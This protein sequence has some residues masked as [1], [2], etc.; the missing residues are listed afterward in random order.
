METLHSKK[1]SDGGKRGPSTLRFVDVQEIQDGIVIL[2]DGSL[3]AILAVSSLNFDLK[4]FEEQEAIIGQYQNFLNSLDFPVQIIVLSRR[5]NI[6]PYLKLLLR[7]EASQTNEL[8]RMQ[9]GEYARFIKSLTE[10]A[11]IMTKQFYII[12][13]FF[14]I[15]TNKKSLFD[16]LFTLLNPARAVIHHREELES[17]KG[18]LFQRVDH[19]VSS[20]AGIGLKL[21]Q[22]N[23]EEVIE[24]LYNSYN[25]TVY[26]LS[27]IRNI[28]SL[29]LQRR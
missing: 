19:V 6:E 9:I 20:L 15:E 16:R 21:V 13:P 26:S 2:R 22:L 14:P 10:V 11:H 4:S 25:P 23:T 5:L 28:E 29:E 3:R 7:Y 18:Q 12:I 8:L 17:Y 24:L 1:L 27:I